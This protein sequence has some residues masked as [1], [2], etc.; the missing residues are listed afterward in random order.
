MPKTGFVATLITNP[1]KAC[2][3]QT[4][5]DKAAQWLKATSISVLAENIAVDL[6]FAERPNQDEIQAALADAPFDLVIQPVQG[7]RKNMLLA[8]MDSTIIAQECIDELA[9]EAGLGAQIAIQTE[10]A[11]RGEI[12]FDTALCQRVALLKDL[13]LDVI[14]RVIENRIHLNRGAQ[15][16]IPT[17]R[18]NGAYTALVSGGFTLFTQKISQRVGFDE[19]HAN[20]LCHDGEK[21][22]GDVAKPIL[23]AEAKRIKLLELCQKL[24]YDSSQVMAVGDGANDIAMLQQ[25]GSGV[26]FHAKP[27]VREAVGMRIDHGDLTALLYIQGYKSEDF[28]AS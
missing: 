21:L 12:D 10:R 27:R 6:F 24:G 23:G 2:L 11:M 16:L 8:D 3:R 9:H 26:A 4:F 20:I 28:V 19:H 15:T 25:A 13:P 22:N 17:M 1:E 5:I 14:D 18:K 7:R